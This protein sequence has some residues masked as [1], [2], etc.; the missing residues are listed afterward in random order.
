VVSTESEY[1]VQCPHCRKPFR[2]K[3]IAGGRALPRLQVPALPAVRSRRAR[4]ER[5]RLNGRFRR[6]L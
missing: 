5:R 2:A 3:V 6:R 4:R 1:E